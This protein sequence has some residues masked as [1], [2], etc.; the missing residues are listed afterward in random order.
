MT[1]GGVWGKAF[2]VY[3]RNFIKLIIIAAIFRAPLIAIQ[4]VAI[5]GPTYQPTAAEGVAAEAPGFGFLEFG[6]LALLLLSVIVILVAPAA[7]VYAVFQSLRG[8][9]PSISNSIVVALSRMLP[10]LGVTVL[11]FL[12]ILLG[13][14]LFVIPGLIII[15]V[16]F[17]A[18]PPVVVEKAGVGEAIG[19]STELT[20]GRRW[21]IFGIF[22]VWY[23]LY[24]ISRQVVML[25]FGIIVGFGAQ[26][27]LLFF[28]IQ[29]LLDV[30]LTALL[31][32][33]VSTVYHDLRIE[34][35]GM[36]TEALA[37]VFD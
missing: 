4:G 2:S 35:E 3:G 7:I 16:L 14:L 30:A 11:S 24:L 6:G 26:S 31:A 13:S 9:S 22:V 15:T 32:V 27:L 19:R 5:F 17:V 18:V 37:A 20:K 21:A 10:I 34:K 28:A 33:L 8:R 1:V 25:I 23:I 36:D 29:Q 12:A